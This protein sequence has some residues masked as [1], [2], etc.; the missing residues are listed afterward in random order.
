MPGVND[1][2][3]S[4]R[5][6]VENVVPLKKKGGQKAGMVAPVNDYILWSAKNQEAARSK[7]RRLYKQVAAADLITKFNLAALGDGRIACDLVVQIVRS[8]CSLR[9]LF[10]NLLNAPEVDL[11]LGNVRPNGRDLL[12]RSC[13]SFTRGHC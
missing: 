2:V 6:S 8:D 7:F 12:T 5:P 9:G 10:G 13:G 1:P 4:P 3:T 11:L